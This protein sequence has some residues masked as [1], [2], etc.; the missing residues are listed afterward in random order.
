MIH[1]AGVWK[2]YRGLDRTVHALEDV[3]LDVAA[4]EFVVVRGPSGCGKSTLLTIIGGLGTPS[5]G[6]VRVAGEDLVAMS[7]AARAQ[8]R[9]R[10][11]GF[12]FQMFHLFP[13]LSV[14]ENVL[15]AA[16]P[17]EDGAPARAQ[18]LLERFQ[19]GHRLAH[20]PAELSTGECQ[21]VAVARA[22]INRPPLILADEPTGNLDPENAAGVLQLLTDFHAEGGTVLLVTHQELA[23][24]PAHRTL[25]LRAG[26]I[27][28][29]TLPAA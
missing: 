22:M 10:H 13:Y 19:L 7:A 18:Q 4:G 14:V 15:A 5:R 16:L 2:T 3:N 25:L 26:R 6:E 20:R 28:Q 24:N 21:R 1:L 17:G 9:A 12:V 8:F 27:E 11:V 23:P 29:P